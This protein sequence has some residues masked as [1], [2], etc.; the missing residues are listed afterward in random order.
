M[1]PTLQA[2]L[3][4][5]VYVRRRL[6][7]SLKGAVHPRINGD[8]ASVCKSELFALREL[9]M[10][11]TRARSRRR[12]RPPRGRRRGRNLEEVSQSLQITDYRCPI[13]SGR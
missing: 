2:T 13:D 3:S 1:V 8:L 12:P 6:I 7:Q 5:R 10:L 4:D 9:I 11:T